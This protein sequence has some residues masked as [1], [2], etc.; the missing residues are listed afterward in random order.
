MP[1]GSPWKAITDRRPSSGRA[2]GATFIRPIENWPLATTS[3]ARRRSTAVWSTSG[4]GP[5]RPLGGVAE[6]GGV[7]EPPDPLAAVRPPPAGPAHVD[8]EQV[9]PEQ[10]AGRLGRVVGQAEGGRQVLAAEAGQPP[11][12]R[13]PGGGPGPAA[14]GSGRGGRRPGRRSGTAARRA[15]GPPPETAMAEVRSRR[16]SYR[17]AVLDRRRGGVDGTKGLPGWPPAT[18]SP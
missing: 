11:P 15:A 17:T 7:G 1:R 10:V 9:G 18:G 2:R 6:L 14:A 16:S 5:A 3:P 13:P 8:L 12:G 4:R